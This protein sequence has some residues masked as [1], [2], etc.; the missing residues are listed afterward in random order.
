MEK[1]KRYYGVAL[2]L[3][4]A[5]VLIYSS[6]NLISP[7]TE[8]LTSIN[9]QIEEKKALLE[10]K[11]RDKSIVQAKIKKIKDSVAGSQKKIYFP[12][13]SDLGNDTLFFTL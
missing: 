9:A 2:F 8:E 1:Y 12:V 10:A 11:L 4:V 13:E 5:F 6:Y 3:F 7:K